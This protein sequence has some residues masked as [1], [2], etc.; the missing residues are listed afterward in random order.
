[1]F[2][3]EEFKSNISYGGIG[4]PSHFEILVFGPAGIDRSSEFQS[5]IRYRAENVNLPTRGIQTLDR[6]IYG[7]GRKFGTD[8]IFSELTM[9]ILLS[10]DLRELT[11]LEKWQDKI[12][13]DYKTNGIS[14]EMY[15]IGFYDDYIGNIEIHQYDS[16]GIPVRKTTCLECFPMQLSSPGLAWDS[17]SQPLRMGATF[18]YREYKNEIL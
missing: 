4:N 16:A 7:P 8:S 17:P 13:G 11:Y 10:E 2:N 9:Q 15:E 3:I 1:M 12:V 5:D 6:K 18:Y 14:K